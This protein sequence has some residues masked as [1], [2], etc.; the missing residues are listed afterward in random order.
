MISPVARGKCEL[1]L[2]VA[3]LQMSHYLPAAVYRALSPVG[4]SKQTPPIIVD[5]KAN[6]AIQTNRQAKMHMLCSSCERRF[7]TEGED[8]VLANFRRSDGQFK[9]LEILR[10]ETPAQFDGDRPVYFG[11]QLPSQVNVEA[12]AYFALSVLWRGSVGDWPEPYGRFRNALGAKYEEEI[13]RFLLGQISF[14]ENA[15]LLVEVDFE[16]PSL[17][18]MISPDSV[19]RIINRFRFRQ[20]FFL[21]PGIRFNVLLGGSTLAF[22]RAMHPITKSNIVFCCFKYTESTMCKNFASGIRQ[23]N[24]KG[25]LA[26]S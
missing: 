9:L 5:L 13:R 22:A 25:K 8:H 2:N 24:I 11:D 17:S 7:D 18:G 3:D 14:P 4:S 15:Y 26:E 21:I 10:A 16:V 23:A 6:T 19:K 20:H 12:Y 1:C